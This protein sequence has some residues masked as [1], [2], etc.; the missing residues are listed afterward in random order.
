MSGHP[1]SASATSKQ[2]FTEAGA[3][4]LLRLG[5]DVHAPLAHLRPAFERLLPEASTDGYFGALRQA[6]G[7]GEVAAGDDADQLRWLAAN[8]RLAAPQEDDL[9]RSWQEAWR[10][11]AEALD[12][13]APEE[14]GPRAR[15][16]LLDELLRRPSYRARLADAL[17]EALRT[18]LTQ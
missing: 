9:S 11:A 16:V 13:A 12:G 17:T 5:L 4:A 15:R 8:L 3:E 6:V 18:Q 7:R 14:L 10:H 2:Q 1:D